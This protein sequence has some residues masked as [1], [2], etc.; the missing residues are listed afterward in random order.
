[1]APTCYPVCDVNRGNTNRKQQYYRAQNADRS[2]WKSPKDGM[3]R[4]E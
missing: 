1:M 4:A 3:C 2:T